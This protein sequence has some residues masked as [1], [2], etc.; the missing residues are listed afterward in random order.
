MTPLNKFAVPTILLSLA[1]AARAEAQPM[2][3][4]VTGGGLGQ[5]LT[6]TNSGQPGAMYFMLMS[7]TTGPSV[8]PGH[9]VGSIDLGLELVGICV[10]L[11]GFVGYLDGSGVAVLPLPVPVM[12]VLDNLNVNF[13]TLRVENGNTFV[14]KSNLWRV[15]FDTPGQYAYTLNNLVQA[16]AFASV[17]ALL[18]G[19]VLVAGGGT[20]SMTSATGLSSAELYRPNLEAFTLLSPMNS[21]RALHR[22]M[23]LLDG[24]VLLTG[25][26]DGL[27]AA[28]AAGEIFNPATG[29][30]TATGSMSVARV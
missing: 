7:L 8:L 3:L 30:F 10:S 12:P 29:G 13:Q 26:V 9:P 4:D 23:R 17:N 18:D 20:G 15:T 2:K 14:E 27:G 22:A 11:P 21:A 1:L 16:R 5:T 28:V 6:L 19:T 24:R 25:G